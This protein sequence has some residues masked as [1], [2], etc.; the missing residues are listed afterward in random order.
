MDALAGGARQSGRR[1]S[2]LTGFSRN[3]Y[4][5]GTCESDAENEYAVSL[6]AERVP[7]AERHLKA[8]RPKLLSKRV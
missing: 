1:L 5:T 6:C 8:G 2:D 3:R 4:N 7:L